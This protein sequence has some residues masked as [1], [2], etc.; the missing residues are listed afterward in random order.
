MSEFREVLGE[1]GGEMIEVGFESDSE[2]GVR[3]LIPDGAS[4]EMA[5]FIVDTFREIIQRSKEE[6]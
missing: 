4:T 1:F 2:D 3:I 5:E 6:K